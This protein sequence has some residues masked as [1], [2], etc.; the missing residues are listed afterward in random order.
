MPFEGWITNAD[1]NA[2][3]GRIIFDVVEKNDLGVFQTRRQLRDRA[4]L[5][6]PVNTVQ[7]SKFAKLSY[8]VRPITQIAV[9]HTRLLEPQR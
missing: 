4:D 5:Q 3:P 8:F 7:S 2:K 9:E 1:E 6:I